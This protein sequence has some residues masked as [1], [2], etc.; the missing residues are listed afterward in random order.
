MDYDPDKRER[1]LNAAAQLIISQG[2][3]APMSVIADAAGVA[4][5]SLYNYFR[6]KDDLILA[7]YQRVA[8]SL[9]AD[10]VVAMEP[11]LSYEQRVER[12]VENYVD[13]IWRDP[14][15]A[16]LYEVITNSPTIMQQRMVGLFMEMVT[17][18]IDVLG[19]GLGEQSQRAMPVS[20]TASF[21]RGAIRNTLKR[22]RAAGGEMTPELRARITR[23][24][25]A[26]LV[27]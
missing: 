9:E 27:A 3:Q 12:Y 11:G 24:C 1:I 25:L 18:S 6:S 5:G 2:L 15:R 16:A 22:H 23:M 20:L 26:A 21:I 10:I 19:E 17:Y 7:V 8:R 4:T 13:H 14:T